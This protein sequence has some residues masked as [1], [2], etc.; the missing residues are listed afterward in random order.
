M[1]KYAA[2]A[3]IA[4]LVAGRLLIRIKSPFW[5]IQPVFHLY[6]LHHWLMTDRVIS[7]DLPGINKY[8]RLTEVETFHSSK[9]PSD[10]LAK[11]CQ[12]IRDHFLKTEMAE[13]NPTDN[14]VL[15]FLENTQLPSFFSIY[16]S[17]QTLIGD[18]ELVKERKV[19]AVIT[20]RPLYVTLNNK[21]FLA[22]YVDN[23]CVDTAYRKQGLAPRLIQSHE[24][25]MRH[26]SRSVQVSLFKRE[27]EMTAIVPLTTYQTVCISAKTIPN[28]KVEYTTAKVLYVNEQ[29]FG[30]AL[31]FVKQTAGTYKC[32]IHPDKMAMAYQLKKRYLDCFLLIENGIVYAAFFF[33]N[34]SVWVNDEKCIEM[35]ASIN[36][37]PH[38]ETFVAAACS[39]MRRACRR[40]KAQRIFIESTSANI[41]ILKALARYDVPILTSCPTAFFLYNYAAYTVPPADCLLLY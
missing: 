17:P 39:A 25:N 36:N 8:V 7:I 27:G 34:S 9:L 21:T 3:I 15:G 11:G 29:S 33:K 13:Y 12:C 23:L 16:S 37:C 28:K 38:N 10:V 1:L 26:K 22:N 14:E 4:L 30:D 40:Y 41:T 24:Y 19:H 31:A 2:L 20:S 5:S 35:V 18:A 6:D 32:C